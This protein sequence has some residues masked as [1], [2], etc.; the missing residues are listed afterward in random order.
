MNNHFLSNNP[1]LVKIIPPSESFQ[2]LLATIESFFEIKHK[3]SG[4]DF[5]I[6]SN[7]AVNKSNKFL[8]RGRP[9]TPKIPWVESSNPVW[10]RI[11]LRDSLDLTQNQIEHLFGYEI[12]VSNSFNF[13]NNLQIVASRIVNN[14]TMPFIKGKINAKKVRL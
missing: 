7:F 3:R 1:E 13:L 12:N 10:S 9:P 14:S 8:F 2:P 4:M 5:P 6:F 11:S